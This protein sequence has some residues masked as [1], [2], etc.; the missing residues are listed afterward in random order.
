MKSAGLPKAKLSRLEQ[1]LR[2]EMPGPSADIAD[3]AVA[4]MWS[5][6]TSLTGWMRRAGEEK[7]LTSFLLAF[8]AG[9]VAGRCGG[10][11]AKH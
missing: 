5:A 10:R 4:S 8:E 7:P 6:F 1:R 2:R 3:Q 9:F 11:H